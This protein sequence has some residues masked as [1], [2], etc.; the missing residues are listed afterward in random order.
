M[1]KKFIV[2]LISIMVLSLFTCGCGKEGAE[3]GVYTIKIAHL[4]NESDDVHLGFEALKE[5]LEERS[6][7]R[8]QVDIFPNGSMAGTDDESAELVNSDAVQIACIA[9]YNT[10]NLS[11]ELLEFNVLDLPYLFETDDDYYKFL[12]SE[13]GQAMLDKVLDVTGNV[14]ATGTY[15]RSWQALTTTDKPVKVPGDLEGM[16]IITGTPEVFRDTVSAWGGNLGTVAFS[17]SYT[18]M[19][20]GSVDGNLRAINLAVTQRY[21][22]VQKYFTLLNQSAMANTTLV[23][24]SWY[25]S[26]PDDL[27]AVFDECMEEYTQIMRDYGVTRQEVTIEELQENGMELVEITDAE[28]QQ[29]IDSSKVVYEEMEDVIGADLIAEVEEILGK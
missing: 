7:G 19:Q 25:E 17:E 29:W 8:F 20:Q 24:W 21:F 4:L 9:L 12:D 5:M 1:K 23:S 15:I 22:E 27:K 10:A 14:W 28:K 16:T 2:L 26:L 3:E 11:D 13:A 18:A 6:D